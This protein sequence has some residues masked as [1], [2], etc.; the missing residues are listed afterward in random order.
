[1]AQ[2]IKKDSSASEIEEKN[3]ILNNNENEKENTE[4][5]TFE[6]AEEVVDNKQTKAKK[7]I[8]EL[9][10]QNEEK[11]NQIKELS[12][13]IEKMQAQMEAF[14][15]GATTVNGSLSKDENEEVLIGCRGIYGG[16]LATSDNKLS[17]KFECDEERYIDSDDIKEL[18]RDS[19][20]KNKI[21][22][23]NDIFYFVDKK[24]YI[25]FKIKKRI[26][27]SPDNISRILCLST[28][29]MIDEF[30]AL[31]NNKNNFRIMHEF[32]FQVVKMLVKNDPRLFN[33]SYDNRH[34]LEE[35]IGQKFDNL[36]ASVG[37]LE[38]LGRKK[39][40]K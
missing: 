5:L 33:W 15:K 18:F 2:I 26:D 13:A 21:N 3:E 9:K 12:L 23:E 27:L 30:N 4:D 39:Y 37:A 11:D 20:R 38:L 34:R 1:M 29:D 8:E 19:K 32:Q 28:H 14:M 16:V 22:F 6:I 10:A 17:F 7:E 35:Y 36:L 31:T 24:Y 40:N 25:K